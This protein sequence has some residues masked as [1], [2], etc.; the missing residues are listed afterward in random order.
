MVTAEIKKG[1]Y[2]YYHCT[3]SRKH[4]DEIYYREEDLTP[5]FDALVRGSPSTLYSGLVEKALK[6]S[7]QDEAAFHQ[8]ALDRLQ[9]ELKKIKNRLDQLYVD[10]LDG[11]VSEG[12]WLEK[13]RVWEAEQEQLVSR[14][15]AH[16]VAD[17]PYY[18]DGLKLL[19]LASRAYE[20]YKKQS[21]TKKTNF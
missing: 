14:F 21:A 20:L 9:A 13:S 16:Q 6:E 4:C 12:F 10:K 2:I 18:E 15:R 3:Q 17:H 11:K 19:E 1:R 5:Q 8:E 7:H